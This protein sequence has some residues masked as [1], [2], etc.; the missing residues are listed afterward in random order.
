MTVR[1][2]FEPRMVHRDRIRAKSLIPTFRRNG[3]NARRLNFGIISMSLSNFD[4]TNTINREID[5]YAYSVTNGN[6]IIG[7]KFFF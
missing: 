7:V 1:A 3:T 4:V 5:L 6:P 2:I